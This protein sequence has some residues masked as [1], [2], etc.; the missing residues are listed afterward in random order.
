MFKIWN[1][2]SLLFLIQLLKHI[3]I[4]LSII[5]V[6]YY[7]GIIDDEIFDMTRYSYYY[8]SISHQITVPRIPVVKYKTGLPFGQS[9][10]S[11]DIFPYICTLSISIQHKNL[12]RMAV[13]VF[14][15]HN[16]KFAY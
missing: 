7:N 9:K 16:P 14:A 12:Q 4:Q 5:Q 15:L 3:H 10:Y 13:L 1:I 11:I 8:L 6:L 2:D